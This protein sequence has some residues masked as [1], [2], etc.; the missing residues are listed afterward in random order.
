MNAR[1]HHGALQVFQNKMTNAKQMPKSFCPKP[2]E[3]VS[4]EIWSIRALRIAWHVAYLE[5]RRPRQSAALRSEN[6]TLQ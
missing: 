3:A 5:E 4:P 6:N 1:P 2:L